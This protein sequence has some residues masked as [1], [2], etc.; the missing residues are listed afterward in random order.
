MCGH[1]DDPSHTDKACF[2]SDSEVTWTFLSFTNL[3]GKKRL[4]NVDSFVITEYVKFWVFLPHVKFGCQK[5]N[6]FFGA[7]APPGPGPPHY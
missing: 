4:K 6:Y 2:F 5:K 7:I 1:N 3:R